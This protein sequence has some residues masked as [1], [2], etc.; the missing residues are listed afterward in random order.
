MQ[1]NSEGLY[2]PLNL[3]DEENYLPD[4]NILELFNSPATV[5]VLNYIENKILQ[6]V[7]G[8]DNDV[9][10]DTFPVGYS[11]DSLIPDDFLHNGI[12]FKDPE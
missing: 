9:H 10:D 12:C 4:S 8:A 1:H 11:Q 7:V 2:S 3:K 5:R 6:Q